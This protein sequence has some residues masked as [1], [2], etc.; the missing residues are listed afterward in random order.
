MTNRI[1]RWL[2][3]PRIYY[4]SRATFI[5]IKSGK[6]AHIKS[7]DANLF[8]DQEGN[9]LMVELFHKKAPK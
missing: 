9:I 2:K 6:I 1:R 7:V 5:D 3:L 8:T 4:D